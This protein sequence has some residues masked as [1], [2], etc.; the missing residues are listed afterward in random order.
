MKYLLRKKDKELKGSVF[1][2]AS[3][4]ISNR[5]LIIRALSGG[6][7]AIDNLSDSDDTQILETALTSGNG[8][9]DAGHAGTAMRFLTGYY[10]VTEGTRV[11]TGSERMKHRPI[12]PLVTALRKLGAHI[13]YM[14]KEGFPPLKIH[15]H[16]LPGG[17]ISIRSDVSSQ[18]ISSLLMIAPMMK[19]GLELQLKGEI[20]SRSYIDLTLQLM[21]DFGIMYEWKNHTIRVPAQR[22]LPLDYFVESDWSAA[23]YWYGMASLSDP[24]NLVLKGLYRTSSQGDHLLASLFEQFGLA[25]EYISHGVRLRKTGKLPRRFDWDFTENPDL[26][27]TFAVLMCKMGIPFHFTGTQ[28]LVI[29]ETD[30]ILALVKE[31]GR[32]GYTLRAGKDSRSLSW[33]GERK[34]PQKNA[35]IKTYQDHR[36]AMAFSLM[37]ID[38]DG[39]M[40]EDPEVVSKSYPRFW[41]H[42]EACEFEIKMYL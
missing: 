2:P 1:L 22:Y 39:I 26:V 33:D 31:L 8:T 30:R 28:S 21:M 15:G 23:S 36:M 6:L 25:T 13:T 41:E 9:L 19:N 37:A 16:R 24:C 20:I 11:L 7:F 34:E 17:H 42:L 12:G 18:F 32:L 38:S 5:L 27:Q 35:S 10:A 4:S 14:E 29:K 40:I 3:K